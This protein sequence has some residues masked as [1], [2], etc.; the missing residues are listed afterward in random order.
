LSQAVSQLV[1]KQGGGRRESSSD[2]F[3]G[4]DALLCGRLQ[5]GHVLEGEE[6]AEAASE[7]LR[8]RGQNLAEGRDSVGHFEVVGIEGIEGRK[9]SC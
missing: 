4:G 6:S 7:R 8:L 9:K 1:L 5:T 3:D 2:R